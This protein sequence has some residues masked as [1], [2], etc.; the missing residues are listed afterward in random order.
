MPPIHLTGQDY[1]SLCRLGLVYR[2]DGV[3]QREQA[4]E[5]GARCEHHVGIERLQSLQ[6]AVCVSAA[7]TLLRCRQRP[8]LHERRE[9]LP[10]HLFEFPEEAQQH[11]V[12]PRQA[13]AVERQEPGEQRR[14]NEAFSI[15][16]C[17]EMHELH[18]DKLELLR[19][20]HL[21]VFRS[22]LAVS[23]D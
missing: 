20:L 12:R 6:R 7:S 5:F 9:R 16:P 8:L 2:R 3:G 18:N 13:C 10:R 17:D 4:W 23:L 19:T 15:P 11:P 14:T 22:F 1:A 21:F